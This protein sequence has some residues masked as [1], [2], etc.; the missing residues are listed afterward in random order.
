MDERKGKGDMV[1]EFVFVM[2]EISIYAGESIT[3]QTTTLY[4]F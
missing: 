3:L 1:F 4:V 2:L